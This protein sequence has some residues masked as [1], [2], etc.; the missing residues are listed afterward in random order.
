MSAAHEQSDGYEQSKDKNNEEYVFASPYFIVKLPFTQATIERPENFPLLCRYFGSKFYYDKV[1]ATDFFASSI[2]VRYE[3]ASSDDGASP[4]ISNYWIK[5]GSVLLGY[6]D[7]TGS[8]NGTLTLPSDCN[9]MIPSLTIKTKNKLTK[10]VIPDNYAYF[11]GMA[12]LKSK[13]EEK[14]RVGV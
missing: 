3:F 11:L 1:K 6:L 10:I 7:E 2:G 4:L 13:I 5:Y 14:R 12:G 9:A 8:V